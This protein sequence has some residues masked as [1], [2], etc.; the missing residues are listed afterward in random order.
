MVS[1]SKIVL[2]QKIQFSVSTQFSSIWPIDRT[3]SGATTWD[4]CGLVSD[5]NEEILCISQRSSISGT[6]SSDY[7]VSYPGHSLRKS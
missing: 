7:L 1:I 2:F 3:Q 4:Q 5:G 6:S